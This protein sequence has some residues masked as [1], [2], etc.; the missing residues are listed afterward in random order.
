VR[1]Y[2]WR[3]ELLN[4][5]VK[6]M[7]RLARKVGFRRNYVMRILRLGFL[8]PDLIEAILNGKLP[9]AVT[10]QP[11]NRPIP[12]GWAEQREFFGLPAHHNNSASSKTAAAARSIPFRPTS[13]PK[14][15]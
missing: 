3:T 15:L 10:L 7:T 4:G 6:T 5:T 2:L 12:L 11:L 1:G 9:L 14:L 8:A 13:S